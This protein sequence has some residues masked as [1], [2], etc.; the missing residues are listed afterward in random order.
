MESRDEF[1]KFEVHWHFIDLE[2]FLQLLSLLS[3]GATNSMVVLKKIAVNSI[4]ID[5]IIVL[6]F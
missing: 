3:S 2:V 1:L 6:V 5:K 4:L